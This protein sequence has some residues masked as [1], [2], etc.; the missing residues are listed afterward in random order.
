LELKIGLLIG[1]FSLGE[2]RRHMRSHPSFSFCAV[3][4]TLVFFVPALAPD[5][6]A[7]PHYKVLYNFT[8]GS[9]GAQPDGLA[10][11]AAGNLYGTTGWGGDANCQC[12][13]V[14]KLDKAGALTVLHTFTNGTD[15]EYPYATLALSGHTLYG[16]ASL[17]GA[18]DCYY[19]YGCGLLFE[20]NIK[21]STF[22]VIHVFHV[23]DGL[24]PSALTLK[25]GVLYGTTLLGGTSRNCD[26]GCGVVYKLVLN[27]RAFTVL[28]SFDAS[29]GSFPDTSLTPDKTGKFLYGATPEGGTSGNCN[30]DGC[31]VVFR[32]TIRT[33]AY[34][35]LYNF[36]GSPDAE[37]PYGLLSMD[38]SGNLYGDSQLGGS[39][40][41]RSDHG[42]GTVF[43]V[44]PGTGTDAVLYD[45]TGVPDGNYPQAGITRTPPGAIYGTTT[46]GGVND[47]GTVF[48][49]A[50]NTETV[51][52]SFQGSDG[53]GPTAAV[54]VAANGNLFGTTFAGGSP[55]CNGY[56]CGVVWEITP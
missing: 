3:L 16:A 28:H 2:E 17:G 32:L 48:E 1:T 6:S 27:T 25:S 4:A 47:D 24:M 8:G 11:D 26:Y 43:M 38:S 21:T 34:D 40:P 30:P 9:D 49:L 51:L 55:S 36:T 45:F 37:Y 10:Q 54:I 22:K 39:Y 20:I 23:Y 42:C 50:D 52:Y 33:G 29:G 41:C 13:T 12:G 19:T 35:V 7:A 46:W 44:G 31:G 15:G 14:Y 5:A 53:S 18:P 56:G